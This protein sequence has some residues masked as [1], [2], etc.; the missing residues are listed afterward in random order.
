MTEQTQDTTLYNGWSNY[1]TWSANLWLQNDEATYCPA[2]A[3]ADPEALSQL[4]KRLESD[5]EFG[6]HVCD[7]QINWQEIYD[8]LHE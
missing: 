1:A 5:P 8:A 4:Y 3:C 2:K 6:D 7:Y